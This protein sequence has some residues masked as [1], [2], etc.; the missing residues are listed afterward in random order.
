MAHLMIEFYKLWSVTSLPIDTPPLYFTICFNVMLCWDW[1]LS[2]YTWDH[3]EYLL[4]KKIKHI[5]Y[6]FTLKHVDL[7]VYLEVI[8]IHESILWSWVGRLD[9]LHNWL[10]WEADLREKQMYLSSMV[11]LL[12]QS[13]S[14]HLREKQMYLPT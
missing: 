10:A 13:L 12:L 3:H 9:P 1:I 11:V 8:L 4:N 6:N 2:N 5:N 14:S 7:H